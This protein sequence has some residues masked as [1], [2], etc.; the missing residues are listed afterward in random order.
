MQWKQR[1]SN[2]IVCVNPCYIAIAAKKNKNYVSFCWT[3]L[4]LYKPFHNI[5]TDIG[6]SA[7]QIEHNWETYAGQYK[8]WHVRK[9]VQEPIREVARSE[10]HENIIPDSIPNEWQVLAGLYPG[11][12]IHL[13]DL[14]MLGSRD[15]D[16]NNTWEDQELSTLQRKIATTFIQSNRLTFHAPQIPI[17][18]QQHVL[19]ATQK[20]AHDI[21]IAHL[22]S[23]T[24]QL[25]LKLIVQGTASTGKS[26]LIKTV[27]NTMV[28]S[29]PH[30]QSPMLLLAPTG[31]AAFNIQASTIHSSLRIPI[32]EMAPL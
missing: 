32:N 13:N 3:E 2:A 12:P 20:K 29:M 28:N 14:D 16:L 23:N 25:P 19:S 27:R 11:L 18:L 4:L 9:N 6:A 8:P 31:V 26:H 7:E 22:H 17:L 24:Q 5:P 1:A 21:I 30:G 10:D 15:F